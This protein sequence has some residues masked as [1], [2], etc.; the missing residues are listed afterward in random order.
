MRAKIIFPN[1]FAVLVVGLLGYLFLRTDLSEIATER[2]RN[3]VLNTR[4]LFERSEALRGFELLHN[5]RSQSMSRSVTD[6][7]APVNLIP[8]EGQTQDQVNKQARR[9]WFKK[10][11]SA[12]EMC[13]ELMLEKTGKKPEIAFLTDRNGLVLARNITANACPADRNVS[14]AIPAVA[15]ALDGEATYSIWS[16]EDSPFRS[17]NPDPKS[18]DLKNT[19][20]LELAAAPVWYGDDIAGVLVA[21]YE[22]SNGTAKTK[23]DMINFELAVLKG[24]DVY[25]SS[26]DTDQARQSLEQQMDRPDVAAKIKAVVEGGAPSGI[27][28]IE[29][30]G[31]PYIAL[32]NPM[33]SAEKK[34]GIVYVMMG[35]VDEAVKDVSALN[36]LIVFMMAAILIVIVAGIVLG[37]HF[38]RPVMAIEEG[39]LKIINGEYNY[40]FE[41]E[42]SEVGGL[43]YR[44]NQLIG[45]LIGEDED[46]EDEDD[47]S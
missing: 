11:V 27:L 22:L 26:F 8:A 40:R 2:L 28:D 9:T 34:D 16:V 47:E 25:S 37:N 38:L 5:V 24:G 21:G 19:G 10:S 33:L 23:S 31:K 30:E 13:T 44:I 18:C 43:S 41:V 32:I 45:V 20:L 15:R 36:M 17:N 39:L 29:V 7:F 12:V 6:A 4:V 46:D 14:K 3:R 1:L 42:S 35:S